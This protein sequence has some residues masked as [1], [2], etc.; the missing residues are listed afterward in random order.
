M[1]EPPSAVSIRT[2]PSGSG[3]T[4]PTRVGARAERSAVQAGERLVRRVGRDDRDELALVRDVERVD[5][6][7]LAG[8]GDGGAHRDGDLVEHD[9]QR[10]PPRPASL[11]AVAR[12]PRV[13]SR[14]EAKCVAEFEQ[15]GRELVHRGGVALDLGLEPDVAACH[16]HG[17]SVVGERAGEDDAVAGHGS[18]CGP[19]ST[20]SATAPTPAVVT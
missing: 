2:M 18:R 8:R 4:S 17:H 3:A 16:H 5:A 12:P 1:R 19:R 10:Q 15:R 20:P 9:R 6:E 14:I 11:S 7:D 13:G